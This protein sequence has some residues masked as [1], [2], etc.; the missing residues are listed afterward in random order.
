MRRLRKELKNWRKSI[1]RDVMFLL[2]GIAAIIFVVIIAY[3]A[4]SYTVIFKKE[5]KDINNLTKN[6][7]TTTKTISGKKKGTA[8]TTATVTDANKSGYTK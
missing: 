8:S 1:M 6:D 7:N 4:I 3:M 2:I 5:L